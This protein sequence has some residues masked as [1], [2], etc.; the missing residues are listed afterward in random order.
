MVECGSRARIASSS[1]E[2]PGIALTEIAYR[3]G[4]P[5]SLILMACAWK[6]S[7]RCETERSDP[8]LMTMVSSGSASFRLRVA[9]PSVPGTHGEYYMQNPSGPGISPASASDTA[10]STW[11]IYRHGGRASKGC[12][13]CVLPPS[14]GSGRAGRSPG[15]RLGCT[16]IHDAEWRASVDPGNKSLSP[17]DGAS[18]FQSG[19]AVARAQRGQPR[20]MPSIG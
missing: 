12:R 13:G 15:C 14:A 19:Q 11:T 16:T 4:F 6:R 8:P 17:F 20:P 7:E 5:R 10:D 9:L 2:R 18:A 1:A 3:L